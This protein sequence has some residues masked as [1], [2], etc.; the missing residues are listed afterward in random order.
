MSFFLSSFAPENV[1]SR[2]RFGGSVPRQPAHSPLARLNLVLTYGIPLCELLFFAYSTTCLV[3]QTDP[4]VEPR[5]CVRGNGA[6]HCN[7]Y[8]RHPIYILRL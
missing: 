7:M 3:E 5:A 4:A 6:I 2:D 1:V 8:L